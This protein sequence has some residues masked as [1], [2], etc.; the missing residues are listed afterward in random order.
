[1]IVE[2]N[3]SFKI[4]IKNKMSNKKAKKIDKN[5]FY[6]EFGIVDVDFIEMVNPLSIP[7]SFFKDEFQISI[8]KEIFELNIKKDIIKFK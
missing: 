4:Y 2:N 5:L 8:F 7:K 6:Y 3:N 1:M